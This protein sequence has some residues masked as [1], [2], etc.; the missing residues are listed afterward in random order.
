MDVAAWR[1]AGIGLLMAIWWMTEAIPIPATALLPLVLFPLLGVADI[2]NAAA[3]YA[4]P[5]IFLFLGGFVIALAMQRWNLH[6]RVALRIVSSIGARPLSV[7]AGFTVAS[8]FL[9]MW[10]SN[11][12]TTLM[13]LPIGLSVVELVQRGDA[14][15]GKNFAVVL[16][17]TIAYSSSIGGMATLIGTPPNAFFA[18]FMYEAY[19]RTIG[20]AEW[21]LFGLPLALVALP[22]MLFIL[23][24]IVYPIRITEI[25]GGQS[26]FYELLRELGPMQRGEKMVRG[27][28]VATAILWI[29]RPLMEGFVPGM[30]DAGIAIAMAL[31]LFILP[32]DLKT[33]TFVMDWNTAERLPWG[34]LILFGGGLSLASAISTTGLASWIGSQLVLF[35]DWPILAVIFI[36]TTTI[37]VLTELTSNTATSAAFLPIAAS[38]AV[39]LGHDPMVLGIPA[40]LA[41]SCAF[42]L[43]VATPP[44]AI[45]FGSGYLTIPQMVRA[46]IWLNLIGVVV[47]LAAVYLLTNVV[48]GV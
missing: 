7:I 38:V 35:S 29:T 3:P 16:M 39:G 9:S 46:G 27:V 8:A 15:S 31:V 32:V 5:L 48:F 2:G 19:G 20:F 11:T 17:L 42:M 22:L 18:G 33:G 21:M 14:S 13:M 36:V 34:V 47:I 10:V 6:R 28:F 30:S 12:A 1:T 23:V 4:N 24:R 45:V 25:P 44:N 41:A 43:P 37:V 26:Y 40:V